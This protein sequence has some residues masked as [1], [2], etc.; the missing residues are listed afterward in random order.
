MIRNGLVT[1]ATIVGVVLICAR[2]GLLP[3]LV[4]SALFCLAGAFLISALTPSGERAAGSDLTGRAKRFQALGREIRHHKTA[5]LLVSIGDRIH[6]L[7]QHIR[8]DP[9]HLELAD[10]LIRH[11]LPK[12]QALVEEYVRL[13]DQPN[14]GEHHAEELAG[15]ETTIRLLDG[16][17]ETQN[18]RCLAED[19]GTFNLDRRGFEEVLRLDY[20]SMEQ[21]SVGSRS[22]SEN[23]PA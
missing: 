15:M 22:G 19:V 14:L 11:H 1:L 16:A 4:I 7:V 21:V 2:F 5:P 20:P 13:V 3:G 9:K 23:S 10:E 18:R 12:A 6:E 17:L 8:R